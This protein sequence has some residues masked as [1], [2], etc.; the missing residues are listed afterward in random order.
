MPLVLF[1]NVAS[2]QA[3]AALDRT[4]DGTMTALRRLST[5]LRINSARDAAAG[6]AVAARLEARA[7]GTGQATRNTNDGLSLLETGDHA[8]ASM[9][10]G[11]QRLRELAVQSLDGALGT[12]DR[13]ALD[14]ELQLGLAEI[15]RTAPATAFNGHAV[16]DGSYG[17][18]LLQ[19]GSGAADTLSIDLSTSLRTTHLGAIATA[20]SSDLRTT[21]GGFEFVGTYTT[22]AIP[23]LD[24]SRP[25]VPFSPGAT[26]TAAAPPTNFA[27]GNATTFTV[28]HLAVTL[29]ANYGTTGAVATAV[30]QQ[31]DAAAS[32]AYV[33]N[34]DPSGHLRITKTASA[35]AAPT[36]PVLAGASGTFA[37]AFDNAA[38]TD[39]TAASPTTHAGFAVDGHAVS[40]VRDYADASGLIA[41]I[42][43]QLDH[44][45]PG[46]YRVSGSAAGISIAHT[47]DTRLPVV[48][49]FTGAGQAVFGRR[50]AAGL[51]LRPGDLTVRVGTGPTCGV[52]GTFAAPEDLARAVAAQVPG[53]VA[54]IDPE[55]ATLQVSARQTVTMGGAQSGGGGAL[56]FSSLVNDPSGSLA[57]I[58][59][60]TARGARDAV[61]R[62]DAALDQVSAQ[63]GTMGAAEAHLQAIVSQD[64]N[65]GTI[66]QA[67]R[68][69]IVD[70][71]MAS[72]S[73]ALARS[74]VL[75]QAGLAMVAQAN[76]R[77]Q[78]VLALLR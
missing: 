63:R 42:Q 48:D 33:A 75:Q 12:S 6:L 32:G 20:T 41:D 3:R 31:L 61:L 2:L 7:R 10:D 55:T 5:G 57:T 76:A 1:N 56:S 4:Q 18:A 16:L 44:G 70:A 35:A 26:A 66:L 37:S 19:V 39:G 36:A 47:D 69:R 22:Q 15:D 54:A 51:T 50:A 73:A 68:G 9:T 13:Q 77:S 65:E 62:I 29:D 71:D 74:T 53:V 78:D 34:I 11:L 30:Q 23:G 45:A 8:L 38:A 59:V 49:D 28:D 43:S 60:K 46:R 64:M 25:A 72:E 24:F 21:G 58:D 27:G 14:T 52:T 17:Q 67:A 40:L